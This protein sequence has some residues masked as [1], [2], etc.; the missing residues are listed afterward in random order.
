MD[1]DCA[2]VPDWSVECSSCGYVGE[3]EE[4]DSGSEAYD[5]LVCPECGYIHMD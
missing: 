3:S 1:A 4:F 2:E 5:V